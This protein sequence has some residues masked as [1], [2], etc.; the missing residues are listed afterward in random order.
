MAASSSSTPNVFRLREESRVE[1][2]RIMNSFDGRKDLVIDPKLMQQLDRIANVT[3]LKKE[4]EVDKIFKLDPL[5]K[6]IVG[7]AKRLYLVRPKISNMKCIADQ[8]LLEKS[9]KEERKYRIVMVPRKLYLCEMIL[10]QE[11]VFGYCEIDEFH[12]DLVAVDSDI[13]SMEIPDYFRSFFLDGEL[14]WMHTVASAIQNIQKLMGLIPNR[15]AIGRG[16]K[17]CFELLKRLEGNRLVEP[18]YSKSE[19]GHLILFDRDIDYVTPLCTQVTYEGLLDDIFG[20]TC[21]LIHGF[22]EFDINISG[23]E[24][25]AKVLLSSKD[26]LYD[27]IRNRHF[28]NVFDLLKTKAK[29]LQT[30]S[31]KRHGL[32]SVTEMKDFVANDLKNLKQEKQNLSYHIGACERIIEM[33]AKADFE[34]YIQTEH[35]LIEGSSLRSCMNYIE[36]TINKQEQLIGTLRL[37]CLLSLTQDGVPARDYRN[38]K[39]WFLHSHGFEHM[40][41]FY[42][43]KKLG[44]FKE[45]TPVFQSTKPLPKMATGIDPL[46]GNSNFK[47]LR[48]RLNLVP[49]EDV[50]LKN[51]VDMS[52]VFSGAYSPLSCK[53]IEQCI[54][55]EGLEEVTKS[56]IGGDR[57]T[58]T[59][60]VQLKTV[61]VGKGQVRSGPAPA[62]VVLVYFLGG[63]TYSEIIALRFLGK[64]T[65]YTFLI[66]TTAIINGQSL[67][68]SIVERPL[69][70]NYNLP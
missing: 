14:S 6:A 2:K 4:C 25:G 67:L 60:E 69:C 27:D 8:I 38:I 23:K 62:K 5:Q 64:K 57:D 20:I 70:P 54:S 46:A 33:K 39:T 61:R 63:C 53:L 16:A 3:F 51:P 34:E 65:G 47:A 17:M 55:R 66:A 37:M 35:S 29:E 36:D 24:Q 18:D 9:Y 21:V 50:D 11:G 44:L 28:T 58:C 7:C 40:L 56:L 48:K 42:N 49:S 43:M 13:M 15:Y 26:V 22:V 45:Q 59:A 31:D 1:L 30:L 10:E 41:T 19:I 52:Y 32:S 12:L 68:K